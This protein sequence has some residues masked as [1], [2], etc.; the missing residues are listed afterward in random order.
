MAVA[1]NVSQKKKERSVIR[2]ERTAGDR[3]KKGRGPWSGRE[4][5]MIGR[6]Q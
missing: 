2:R 3:E 1:H 5:E 4:R 6:A